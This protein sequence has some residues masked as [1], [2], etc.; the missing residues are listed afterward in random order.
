MRMSVLIP[1]PDPSRPNIMR[2]PGPGAT[3]ATAPIAILPRA[4]AVA[5]SLGFTARS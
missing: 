4:S 5:A 3:S 2:P 1:A